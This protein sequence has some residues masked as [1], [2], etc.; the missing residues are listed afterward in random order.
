MKQ[1]SLASFDIW[2]T[3]IRRNCHPDEVKI[4]TSRYIYLKYN[5]FL[6]DS[7]T[8]HVYITEE[9]LKCEREIGIANK[10]L[11]Y[12]DEY[13]ISDVFSCLLDRVTNEIPNKKEVVE[14]LIRLEI[15]HEKEI[16]YLDTHFL[17]IL[18]KVSAKDK[19]FI[20]DFYMDKEALIEIL[21]HIGFPLKIDGGYVSCDH[22]YNKRSG[23][24]FKFVEDKHKVTPSEHIHFGDN[25]YS[26][27]KSPGELGIETVHYLYNEE[28]KKR[29]EYTSR[30]SNR[31]NS[32]LYM[33]DLLGK[34]EL[35]PVPSHLQGHSQE[36][37]KLGIRYSIL[38]YVF[39]LFIIEDTIKEN[40]SKI[41]YFT[42]EGE[43]FKK[44]HD[45]IQTFNPFG[46]ALP[47]SE[48]LEV[49]RLATFSPSLREVS[50]KEF[51][52]IWNQY[53][54][55]SMK[56]LFLSLDIDLQNYMKWLD[57]YRLP[58]EEEIQYPWLD[59][60]VKE[61]FADRNFVK[62]LEQDIHAKKIELMQYMKQ[63]GI[64]E[65]TD[66]ISV[67]DIGWRGTIQ[68]NLANIYSQATIVGY[69]LGLYDFINEQ[70]LNTIKKSFIPNE[71]MDS[72]LKF[73]AP[74]EMLCN[75]PSGSVLRYSRND[76]NSSIAVKVQ[77]GGEDSV[78]HN[79]TSHFQAGVLAA[80][81]TICDYLKKH[82]FTSEELKGYCFNVIEQLMRFP[83]KAITKAFF[84]LSHNETFGVGKFIDKRKPIPI[85]D[86]MEA[87]FSK[88][89]LRNL[90]RVLDDTSWPQGFLIY[91]NLHLLNK[92]YNSRVKRARTPNFANNISGDL[93]A[94][95]EAQN[96]L[97]EERYLAI[98]S[99]DQMIKE[100]DQTIKEQ[101]VMLE[102]RYAA[103][104][105]MEKMI[106]ERDQTIKQLESQIRE[107]DEL[108]LKKNINR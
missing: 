57:M 27:V 64:Y 6:K 91:H 53:S 104:M 28:E 82:P 2:D 55:Q 58:S 70:P 77:E 24:L 99:M 41:Y 5:A 7:Y 26:D 88:N 96:K 56:S 16:S 17:S 76:D 65:N 39:I 75:S 81:E 72:V 105:E 73:V 21:E 107:K 32:N 3:V 54:T 43:F 93:S 69:Y 87:V 86:I 94:V 33:K 36:V 8:N 13:H 4:F 38:F 44:I 100:R 79:S 31:S 45:C 14:E 106:I 12:D 78:Y 50:L 68:D 51:M 62:Q 67:V 18:D 52:R 23:K 108:L 85:R 89:P 9:R 42:R 60:R 29:S 63:K 95:V 15:N 11:G 34:L 48:L 20:S 47:E 92:Y 46:L 98:Q 84:S 30:F 25:E 101:G 1:Y 97:L 19:V 10:E 61:L 22:L 102:E 74:M 83:P 35:L 59:Q 90:K 71:L 103:M 49:S 66:K 40:V 80:G 37:Y